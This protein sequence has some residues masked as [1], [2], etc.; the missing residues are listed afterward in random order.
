MF[1]LEEKYTRSEL[2]KM[3]IDKAPMP[4]GL[5]FDRKENPLGEFEKNKGRVVQRGHKIIQHAQIFW[6]WPPV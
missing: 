1:E 4:L 6:R 3:G 5:I 2:L